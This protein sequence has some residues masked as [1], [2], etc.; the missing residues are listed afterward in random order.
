MQIFKEYG[1]TELA[2]EGRCKLDAN[3]F[4]AGYA[5]SFSI[6][7][8]VAVIEEEYDLSFTTEQLNS[9]TIRSISGFV[10]IIYKKLL[11]KG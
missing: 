7:S 5:D 3:I 11:S 8:I 4:E 1:N 2:E 6:T 10:D 9:D